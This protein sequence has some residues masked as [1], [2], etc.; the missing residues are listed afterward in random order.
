MKKVS[1]V[2]DMVFDRNMNPAW[3]NSPES[4]RRWLE[5][6]LDSDP[7]VWQYKVRIGRT[8]EYVTV[9][10]YLKRRGKK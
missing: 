7:T 3:C 1:V 4:C 8:L 9:I 6:R 10:D 2:N 5:F